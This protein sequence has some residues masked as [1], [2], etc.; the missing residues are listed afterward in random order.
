M[1]MET[2]C[3]RC[4]AAMSCMPEGGCWCAELPKGPMPVIAEGSTDA[5]GC[6]CRECLRQELER[7]GAAKPPA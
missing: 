3:A 7:Q 4:G 5:V 1:L 2:R 6:F